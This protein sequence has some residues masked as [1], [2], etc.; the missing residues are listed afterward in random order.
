LAQNFTAKV[1]F[2][3]FKRGKHFL[4]MI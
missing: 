4:A 3:N 1:I 2:S